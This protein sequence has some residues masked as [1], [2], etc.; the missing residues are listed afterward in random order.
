MTWTVD[1]QLALTATE[2]VS[3]IQTGRLK[4]T[5]YVATL[6]AR[7]AAL[8]TLNALTALNMEGALAAARRIDALSDEARSAL[9]LAGLPVVVKDNINTA[10]LL[11]S[12]GTPA[13]E[14]FVPDSNAPSVQRLLDAGA[15]VL[16]K[17]NMH[18]LAFGI[19]STNLAPH[20]GAVRNPYDPGL[21]P[22]GSSGGTAAAIAARIVP[23]GL[24]TDTGGSTRIPAALTGTVGFRP[25]VGDGGA[26]RRY[27][28]PD[29]VLP[30][31]HT[32]DTV[33]P[34]ART[35]ADI[36]LLDGVISGDGALPTVAL[37]GLRIGLPAPLWDDLDHA[38]ENVAQVALKRLEAAGVI[39]VPVT[40]PRLLP[41]NEQV[42]SVI[43]IYEAREDVPA[44]LV[45]NDAPV[46]TL[47]E[48]AARI[49]SPDV[50][51]A[52]DA[53]L[54]NPFAQQYQN[55][56]TVLRPQLQQHYAD[57]FAAEQLDA[58]LFP[59]TRLCAV[60]IDELAGSSTVSIN[61]GAPINEMGAYLR[62]TDPASNAGIPGL[63][64]PA[65][66]SAEG[67]PVGFEIDGPL[68]SDRRLL[69][70]GAAFEQVLD[71]LPAP[72]L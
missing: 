61:G 31:S 60:P 72:T 56:L 47:T 28:D 40:M 55:A 4:A 22:G 14:G 26:E 71:V 18:E 2:A 34:M 62:N 1:E 27:H 9:P 45:A 44:W 6:L 15:I 29:A 3:A 35:V 24:G 68:G 63:S 42:G 33:G 11:T 39:F 32:R 25:S 59:T 10:G 13:L 17:A 46:K 38:V 54:A 41:L 19:T 48:I 67:L 43:A 69:A 36:V 50:R 5:D 53:I 21:I 58:L 12:A 37:Q 57:T 65:G 51:D 66:L 16:G 7:A 20:A 64:L 23:A 30:I 70:I 52:Y 49:A 8:Q